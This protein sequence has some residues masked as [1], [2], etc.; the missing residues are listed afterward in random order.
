M[1]GSDAAAAEAAKQALYTALE[2]GLRLLHPFMPFVTEELWQRLPRRAGDAPRSIMVAHY[3]SAA[4]LDCRDADAEAS[5][6]RLQAVVKEARAAASAKGLK[7]NQ[8]AEMS[9]ACKV[10]PSATAAALCYA[11]CAVRCA[12]ERSPCTTE[13]TPTRTRSPHRSP[14]P[15]MLVVT[16]PPAQHPAHTCC[17][18]VLPDPGSPQSTAVALPRRLKSSCRP[19]VFCSSVLLWR[20]VPCSTAVQLQSLVRPHP[21]LHAMQ[22]AEARQCFE[23]HGGIVATLVANCSALRALPPDAPPPPGAAATILDPSSTLY[24]HLQGLLDPRAEISKL[25]KQRAAAETR[26]STLQ[27]YPP[28]PAPHT[29]PPTPVPTSDCSRSSSI[30]FALHNLRMERMCVHTTVCGRQVRMVRPAHVTICM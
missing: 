5:M 14:P 17:A 18:H 2:A 26:A 15:F 20:A 22:D 7:P 8:A 27:V 4:A 16:T 29:P 11:C 12:F 25:E 23:A 21:Q 19:I 13:R 1:Q 6:A 3:P 9:I 30:L 24:L 10:R 28:H